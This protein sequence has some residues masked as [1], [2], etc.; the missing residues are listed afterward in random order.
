[1]PLKNLNIIYFSPLT[2]DNLLL[3]GTRL[4]IANAV[5]GKFLCGILKI[6]ILFFY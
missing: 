3:R 4:K 5:Y 6:E 2:N 1:V